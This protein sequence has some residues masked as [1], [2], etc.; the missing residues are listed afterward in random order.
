MILILI[1]LVTIKTCEKGKNYI[2]VSHF[3]TKTSWEY[4]GVGS[5]LYKINDVIGI[6]PDKYDLYNSTL[7]SISG[8]ILTHTHKYSPFQVH[9]HRQ[10]QIYTRYNAWMYIQ[11]RIDI[12]GLFQP[13]ILYKH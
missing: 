4:G 1:S 5:T 7:S 13:P 10:R 12:A 2:S 6:C 9:N 3:T 8:L 11:T